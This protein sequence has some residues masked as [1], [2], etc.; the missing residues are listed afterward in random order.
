MLIIGEVVDHAVRRLGRILLHQ[1]PAVEQHAHLLIGERAGEHLKRLH[2]AGERAGVVA[3][4][5]VARAN[6]QRARLPV[7]AALRDI[8]R[9]RE[10][11]RHRRGVIARP[12]QPELDPASRPAHDGLHAGGVHAHVA[13]AL[14]EVEA[15]RVG[16][17]HR[18]GVPVGVASAEDQAALRGA[19][20]PHHE[21]RVVAAA[22]RAA[23]RVVAEVAQ[24]DREVPAVLEELDARVDVRRIVR[25]GE[26]VARARLVALGLLDRIRVVRRRLHLGHRVAGRQG[27]DAVDDRRLI[28]FK[29]RARRIVVRHLHLREPVARRRQM[30]GGKVCVPGAEHVVDDHV[31]RQRAAVEVRADALILLQTQAL[32]KAAVEEVRVELAAVRN[33]HHVAGDADRHAVAARHMDEAVAVHVAPA[34]HVAAEDDGIVRLVDAAVVR[35]ERHVAV[36]EVDRRGIAHA[37]RVIELV[38]FLH[39]A[40]VFLALQR[41]LP[42]AVVADA[43]IPRRPLDGALAAVDEHVAF[44]GE[45]LPV[46]RV[47]PARAAQQRRTAHAALLFRDRREVFRR[48][49]AQTAADEAVPVQPA[50]D[51]RVDGVVGIQAHAAEGRQIEQVVGDVHKAELARA[52]EVN[53][54]IAADLREEAVPDRQVVHAHRQDRLTGGVVRI[55]RAREQ[56]VVRDVPERAAVEGDVLA[57]RLA[58][59]PGGILAQGDAIAGAVFPVVEHA[60]P[61]A[62]AER[63]VPA[64]P[65]VQLRAAVEDHVA[66]FRVLH[67]RHVDD[68]VLVAQAA[69]VDDGV[70]AGQRVGQGLRVVRHAVRRS[71][72]DARHP[73]FTR[74]TLRAARKGIGHQDALLA[75]HLHS[76]PF[77]SSTSNSQL[78]QGVS[79]QSPPVAFP[80]LSSAA[81]ST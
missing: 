6:E 67:A 69:A 59:I 18:G 36:D 77:T 56:V 28:V 66:D 21:Q 74:R 61:L 31:P 45:M 68:A 14:V 73:A 79:T 39:Q 57:A 1:A 52:V 37:E 15:G 30:A 80:S 47:R 23:V 27:D 24:E 62:V 20:V 42:L 8:H 11:I 65:Q 3:V 41:A 10:V 78:R 71:A 4:V 2:A 40:A 44:A 50:V 58:A 19:G 64:S 43:R 46:G 76:C 35:V 9:Q 33:L 55:A 60:L 81:S 26:D 32:I 34:H 16:N 13:L 22:G 25:A 63:D 72:G 12:A 7:K 29:Q 5:A 54:C 49:I 48:Q 70:A 17:E 53:G 38:L 51:R 75:P